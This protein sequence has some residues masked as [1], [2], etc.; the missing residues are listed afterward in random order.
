LIY[1]S[2]QW[3]AR[4]YFF[5]LVIRGKFDDPLMVSRY[6]YDHPKMVYYIYGL[7][8]YPDY[9]LKKNK[10]EVNTY[11]EY[12]NHYGFYQDN[13]KNT[14][15]WNTTDAAFYEINKSTF[16]KCDIYLCDSLSLINKVR[17]INVILLAL[18]TVVIFKLSQIILS[19]N[20]FGVLA[21]FLWGINIII[22]RWSLLAQAEAIFLL[23]FNTGLLLLFFTFTAKKRQ[24]SY[25]Y[26][27]AVIAALCTSTKLHGSI[28]IVIYFFLYLMVK[29]VALGKN[30]TQYFIK[31]YS[32]LA[33]TICLY[34]TIV[35]L[36]NPL[37]WKGPIKKTVGIVRYRYYTALVQQQYSMSDALP[38]VPS[39]A[40]K[41]FHRLFINADKN[42]PNN[43]L[44]LNKELIL[45]ITKIDLFTLGLVSIV[46][47][48]LKKKKVAIY[49]MTSSII[50]FI[51][52]LF[53]IMLDWE[54]YY[55]ILILPYSIIMVAGIQLIFNNI[56]SAYLSFKKILRT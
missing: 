32:L 12:L 6:S 30:R 8:L 52:A 17:F 9:L 11:I 51:A 37:L 40:G 15:V 3:V 16:K 2:N 10:L 46:I 1:P 14:P 33:G 36:L 43:E 41:I 42:I 34:I 45:L 18:T 49:F 24:T 48:V 35:F 25:H 39:R 7:T 53:Y 56:P 13:T 47:A 50:I 28:L 44:S 38:D 20:I 27:F 54:R 5:D 23:F 31:K 26:L 21:T 4:S 55:N 19:S 22:M 29:R